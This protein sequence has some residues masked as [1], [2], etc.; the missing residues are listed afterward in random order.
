MA[1]KILVTGGTVFVSRYVAEYYVRKGAEVYVLNRGNRPQ[2]D[3]VTLIQADRHELGEKLRGYH[4]DIIVDVTAYD[5][6]DVEDLLDAV[7]SYE[8]YI[9]ISSS[10]VYPEYATQPFVEDGPIGENR[11]WKK[12]GTD[13]IAAEDVLLR[14]NPNA[15]VLRPPYL[16]GP[17]NNVYREAF[18]FDCALQNRRF[19]LPK[20]G[21]MKLQFFHVED[22]CRFIDV[23]LE[24]RPKQHIF[25]VGNREC[26]S[27]KDWVKLCYAV[28]GKTAEFVN[29]TA[30]VEQRKYFSF[31]DYE[32][33]LDVTA[34]EHFMPETKDLAEGLKEAFAWY[35]DN[36][37]LVNRKNYF[38][39]IDCNL[40]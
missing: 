7:G 6:E 21:Q 36:E 23:I 19:Y 9:L 37:E 34:Q 33:Y 1:K 18:V 40:M 14:R 24:Q 31:Y 29:V 2:S 35:L 26:V 4:F 17:M 16:Y 20:D 3:G 39:F 25:N 11:F 27:I 10:A 30:D 38:E 5:A 28:A 12:Y 8:E 13:K 32:Y 15:Y 22:L